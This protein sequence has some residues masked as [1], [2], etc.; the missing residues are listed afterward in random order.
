MFSV[1]ALLRGACWNGW[2]CKG[3][4]WLIR[5]VSQL[6]DKLGAPKQPP[7]VHKLNTLSQGQGHI[8]SSRYTRQAQSSQRV[9]YSKDIFRPCLEVHEPTMPARKSTCKYTAH[10]KAGAVPKPQAEPKIRNHCWMTCQ[11]SPSYAI[12]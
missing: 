9:I 7:Q 5:Y 6:R 11:G 8:R 3:S 4:C 1:L 10:V 2:T 12:C